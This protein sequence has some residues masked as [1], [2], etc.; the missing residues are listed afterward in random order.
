MNDFDDFSHDYYFFSRVAIGGDFL[1][2][3]EN[4]ISNFF[5]RKI[6]DNLL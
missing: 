5:Y 4:D 6:C 1:S 2:G 3:D